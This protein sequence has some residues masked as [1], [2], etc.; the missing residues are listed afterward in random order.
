VAVST[1][2]AIATIY[3]LSSFTAQVAVDEIDIVEVERDQAVSVLVDAYPDA[4]LRGTVANVAIAPTSTPTG[5]ATFAVSVRLTEVPD[6][7]VLRVGLTASAEIEVRRVEA[8]TTVPT[9]ALLRR[10]A[11][12]SSSWWRT[13]W[14]ARSR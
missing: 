3:D 7:V 4:E 11:R 8:E 12:R 14:H 13:G 1:G 2:Q 10:G 6:E 9:S 5:G